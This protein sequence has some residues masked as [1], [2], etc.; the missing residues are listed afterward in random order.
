M[1]SQKVFETRAIIAI[2]SRHRSVNIVE[3]TTKIQIYLKIDRPI[4]SLTVCEADSEIVRCCALFICC[5]VIPDKV[6]LTIE[7]SEVTTV[8][9]DILG[10]GDILVQDK[11]SADGIIARRSI[12]VSTPRHTQPQ[13]T[14]VLE[15]RRSDLADIDGDGLGGLDTAV[16]SGDVDMVGGVFLEMPTDIV[17]GSVEP[18][19]RSGT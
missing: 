12:T 13:L 9:I 10:N 8:D 16:V 5:F 14:I 17:E 4:E 2:L 18:N 11:R 19:S 7:E 1:I 15:V 3:F 6:E